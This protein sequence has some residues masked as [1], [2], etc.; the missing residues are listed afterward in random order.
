MTSSLML[1]VFLIMSSDDIVSNSVVIDDGSPLSYSTANL[2]VSPGFIGI[3]VSS[4]MVL[5]SPKFWRTLAMLWLNKTCFVLSMIMAFLSSDTLYS[6]FTIIC[7]VIT[8]F[9]VELLVILDR[10]KSSRGACFLESQPSFFPKFNKSV[11][12]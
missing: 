1:C 11:E 3:G 9:S 10:T 2:S 6:E 12:L 7:G 4:T 5:Y 8:L